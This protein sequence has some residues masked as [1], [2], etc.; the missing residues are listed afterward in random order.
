MIKAVFLVLINCFLL[1]SGQTLWKIGLHNIKIDKFTD[2]FKLILNKYI[3]TGIGIYA[4]ATFFWLVI[5]KKYDLTK[6]YPLQSMSYIIAIFAGYF[7]LNESISKNTI[8]G[9]IIICV[10]IFVLSS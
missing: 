3:I 6:V 2:I 8:L 5:L 7:I 1:V 9:I 10:G 4:F